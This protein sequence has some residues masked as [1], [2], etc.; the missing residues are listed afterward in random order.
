MPELRT[1]LP[2]GYFTSDDKARMDVD[3][4]HRW[5]TEE[6]PWA[7]GRTRETVERSI[8]FALAI[9]LYA[10]NGAQAGFARAVTDY[11]LNARLTD[12]FILPAHRG[13]GLATGLVRAVLEHPSVA[14]VRVW[15]LNTDDAHLLYARFGF[16][17]PKQPEGEME[18]RRAQP[19]AAR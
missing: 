13:R 11:T 18:W 9:G 6:S 15:S 19:P 1:D 10:P 4:I 2:G 16:A 12:V 7:R 5:L 14:T 3:T 8:R 17:S